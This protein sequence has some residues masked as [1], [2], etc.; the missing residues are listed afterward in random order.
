MK[1]AKE[2][3]APVLLGTGE[4]LLNGI[5]MRARGYEGVKHIA[6][7]RAAAHLILRKRM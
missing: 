4:H 7:A 3:I 6:G 1:V 2:V 5:D